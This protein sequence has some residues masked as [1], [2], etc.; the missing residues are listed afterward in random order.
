MDDLRF[1]RITKG[2]WKAVRAEIERIAA[3]R[4]IR[5]DPSV[6]EIVQTEGC[7]LRAKICRPS[8]IRVA[9]VEDGRPPRIVV[10]AVM[11]RSQRTYDIFSILFKASQRS[12]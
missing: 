10:Q 8:Q 4:H 3:V 7:W 5:L 6:C 9:F 11:R 12:K 1:W 2:E